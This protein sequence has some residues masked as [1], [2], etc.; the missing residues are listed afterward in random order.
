MHTTPQSQGFPIVLERKALGRRSRER[1]D[2]LRVAAIRPKRHCVTARG[3]MSSP[4]S[5][6]LRRL[7]AY[8][9]CGASSTTILQQRFGWSAPV[10]RKTW[11][12]SLG[13][14]IS[15]AAGSVRVQSTSGECTRCVVKKTTLA[16]V[17]TYW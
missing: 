5:R 17:T 9:W 1:H 16:V 8:T 6:R 4:T 13:E 3:L 15:L 2:P 12:A 10:S 11:I 7:E 14:S